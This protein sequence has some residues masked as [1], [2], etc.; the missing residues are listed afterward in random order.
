MRGEATPRILRDNLSHIARERESTSIAEASRLP[1]AGKL[2]GRAPR[3]MRRLVGWRRSGHGRSALSSIYTSSHL[4][5]VDA[6]I[7]GRSLRYCVLSESLWGPC[8][9]RPPQV[10]PQCSV[11][12]HCSVLYL[13]SLCSPFPTGVCTSVDSSRGSGL[14]NVYRQVRLLGVGP[15]VTRNRTVWRCSKGEQAMIRR[16][17]AAVQPGVPSGEAGRASTA[18]WFNFFSTE[19]S[20]PV[21]DGQ[22]SLLFSPRSVPT[23]L[24]GTVRRSPRRLLADGFVRASPATIRW[25]FFFFLRRVCV[26]VLTSIVFDALGVFGLRK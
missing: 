9:P 20:L 18:S 3:C 23:S 22:E 10:A 25:V 12:I 11:E 4:I 7:A 13:V 1:L 5:S 19:C 14:S 26:C 15:A 17:F 6:R 21:D 24:A 2:R 16:G 8:L